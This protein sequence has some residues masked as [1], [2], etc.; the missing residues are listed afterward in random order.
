M[1]KI[2]LIIVS[3]VVISGIG[4]SQAPV[5]RRKTNTEHTQPSKTKKRQLTKSK[6]K[7]EKDIKQN[8]EG[9]MVNQEKDNKQTLES[10]KSEPEHIIKDESNSKQREDY[11]AQSSQSVQLSYPDG[12]INRHGYIDLGLPSGIK[13]AVS[14]VGTTLPEASGYYFAWGETSRK[15]NY[16]SKSSKTANKKNSKLLSKGIIDSLGNLTPSYDAAQ[17]NW[18]GSWRMP[19]K[20]EIQELKE[21][22]QW[23]WS[24]IYGKNGYIVVGP[25]NKSIFLPA[26]GQFDESILFNKD[27]I[28]FYWTSSIEQNQY[29]YSLFMYDKSIYVSSPLR[30]CGMSVR[31]VS[32]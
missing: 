16:N 22:C 4:F 18:G 13:W 28:G 3:I 6:R 20:D 30:H 24:T 14:N 31:A 25:N 23:T 8:K 27:E 19:T 32:D 26:A 11:F 7:S 12:E 1:K 21:Y 10:N 17:I 29:A 9:I 5:K 2:I 15:Y